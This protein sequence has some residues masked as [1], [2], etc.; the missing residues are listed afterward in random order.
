MNIHS[1]LLSGFGQAAEGEGG[2]DGGLCHRQPGLR[3]GEHNHPAGNGGGVGRL[4][5]AHR[6]ADPGAQA[7]T[8]FLIPGADRRVSGCDMTGQ[9]FE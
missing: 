9:G 7:G 3:G 8:H 1:I 5:L 4:Y 2:A 6:L